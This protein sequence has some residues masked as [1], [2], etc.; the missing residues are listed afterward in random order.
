MYGLNPCCPEN[1]QVVT[2]YLSTRFN[3]VH[4]WLPDFALSGR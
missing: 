3:E 1:L 2:E 4:Y